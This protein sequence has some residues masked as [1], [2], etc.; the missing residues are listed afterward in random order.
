M[1][2]VFLKF[3]SFVRV[4]CTQDVIDSQILTTSKTLID[5]GIFKVNLFDYSQVSSK[6]HLLKVSQS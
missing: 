2:K 1:S 4:K 6:F 5:P 3:L